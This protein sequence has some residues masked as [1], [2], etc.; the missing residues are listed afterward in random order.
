MAKLQ[1]NAD[2]EVQNE[3]L[4]LGAQESAKARRKP[5]Q[6]R[7]KHLDGGALPPVY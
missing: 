1:T 5:I 4:V 6:A 2:T 7:E 3:R